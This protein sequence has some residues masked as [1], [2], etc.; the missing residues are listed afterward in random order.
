MDNILAIKNLSFAYSGYD[1]TKVLNN[2]SFNVEAGS[3]VSILGPNGSGK[4][5]LINLISKVLKNYN[6]EIKIKD[7]D[8]EKISTR[9]IAKLVAVVPQY[10][11]PGFDFTVGEIVHHGKIPVCIK[12]WQRKKRGL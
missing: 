12:V 4:S 2:L 10:I 9:D 11:N 1:G 7:K 3:F 6:G 8:I 5:T